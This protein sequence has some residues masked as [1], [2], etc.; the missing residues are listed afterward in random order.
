MYLHIYGSHCVLEIL[1]PSE[2]TWHP[3]A[4]QV[5]T[6]DDCCKYRFISTTALRLSGRS[7]YSSGVQAG[8]LQDLFTTVSPPSLK[9]R[10][11]LSIE[12][13]S[14]GILA[15]FLLPPCVWA[16]C[17]G[18]FLTLGCSWWVV[19]WTRTNAVVLFLLA[20]LY[21]KTISLESSILLQLLQLH[22]A[23]KSVGVWN[24]CSIILYTSFHTMIAGDVR[25][26]TWD[27]T[28]WHG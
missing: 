12:I 5:K 1:V 18:F 16:L 15:F 8:F 28:C 21:W 19:S 22:V 23:W 14:A 24:A 6:L 4:L 10:Q 20:V 2:Q 11:A 3:P 17:Q 27:L 9:V 26:G 25:E 13:H 7:V